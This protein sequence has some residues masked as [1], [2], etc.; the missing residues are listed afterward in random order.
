ML[1]FSPVTISTLRG[2]AMT[3]ALPVSRTMKTKSQK[4]GVYAAPATQG[5]YMTQI[6]GTT[7]LRIEWL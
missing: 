2:L 5:P 3:I 6:C 4:T 1:I 7:P